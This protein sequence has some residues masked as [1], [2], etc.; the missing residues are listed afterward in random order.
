SLSWAIYSIILRKLNANY[1]V[2]FIT[3]KTFFYGIITALPFVFLEPVQSPADILTNPVAIGNI[4]FLGLGA[5]LI[6]FM[7]WAETV[8]KVGAIKANN[9]MY[10][11]SIVTLIAAAILL[12]EPVTLI[13]ILGIVLILGGLWLGDFLTRRKKS[14][15]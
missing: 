12:S 11:Q 1:D 15:R 13:G 9:Y 2:W 3:R 6:G 4:L 7:L 8:K 10:L 5:S 14:A